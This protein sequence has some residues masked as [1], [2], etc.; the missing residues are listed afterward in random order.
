MILIDN[1]SSA[2]QCSMILIDDHFSAAG[3][4]QEKRR[5]GGDFAR[6]D[7]GDLEGGTARQVGG[8][9]DH[10]GGR[11]DDDHHYRDYLD[12]EVCPSTRRT[13]DEGEKE[14]RRG[15]VVADNHENETSSRSFLRYVH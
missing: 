13:R 14:R 5:G 9:P 2:V 15:V 6:L 4:C 11:G 12:V 10:L 1:R 7:R 3:G 8:H